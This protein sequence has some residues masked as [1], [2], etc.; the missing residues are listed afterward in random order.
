[1]RNI[2]YYNNCEA[3]RI[4]EESKYKYLIL[5]NGDKIPWKNLKKPMFEAECTT[6]KKRVS[7]NYYNG[8]ERK[9]YICPSCARSGELHPMYGRNHTEESKQKMSDSNKGK[10]DGEKN[11]FYGRCHTEE[12]KRLISLKKVG[13]NT[14]KDA[15]FYGRKHTKETQLEINR[16][17]KLWRDN[18]TEEETAKLS[19]KMSDGQKM[20]RKSEPDR[21][22]KLKQKAA[23][24][25]QLSQKRYQKNKFE[26]RLEKKLK[27]L[28]L[29]FEYSVIMGYHQY[30][31]GNKKYRILL[32]AN[33]D[34]WH[35]CDKFYNE[36][37]SDGKRK[38]NDIQKKNI[39]NDNIK[40]EFAKK[41]KIS[42]YVIW[43]H[44]LND[45]NISILYDIKNEIQ[46]KETKNRTTGI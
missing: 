3:E 10:Y 2:Y 30:D 44:E 21:Y 8:L 45:G 13:K 42:L 46:I 5:K 31:F 40:R 32:E 4:L 14:G 18:L 25:S 6:C 24:A 35:G 17:V 12:T 28:N 9:T 37:G 36:D 41:H 22:R 11:P 7:M 26:E 15:P 39:V 20:L 38:L 1:M 34:Y 19:K 29:E 43:E 27:E 16:K 33:G 23:R